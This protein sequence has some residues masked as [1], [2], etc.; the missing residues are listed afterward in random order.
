MIRRPPRSTLFPYTTLFRSVVDAGT[1]RTHETSVH[2][3]G[4]SGHPHQPAPGARADQLAHARALKVPRHG[5]TARACALV[6]DHYLRP[7]NTLRLHFVASHTIGRRAERLA[8]EDLG[9]VGGQQTAAVEALV[10]DGGLLA[11]L[12]VKVAVERGQ[13]AIGRVRHID[14]GHLAAGHL[15]DLAAILLYRSV[16][17]TSELQA[18]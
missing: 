14:V 10:H 1:G 7:K 15:V 8:V 11:D 12:R 18:P 2:Q 4:P 3:R 5:V 17:H 6:D 13:A 16:A 9:D